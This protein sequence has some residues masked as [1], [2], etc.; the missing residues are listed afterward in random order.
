V[1]IPTAGGYDSAT[2]SNPS[3]ALTDFTLIIDLSRMSSSWW[4]DVNTSDGTRGRASKSDG[5]T[6]LACDWIDF[7]NSEET[8]LLRVKFSGSLA[9]SGTQTIRIYPP[10]TR[11]AAYS[12]SDTYGS[13]NAYDSNTWGYYPLHDGNDRTSNSRDLTAG[14]S[15][16]FGGGT[17]LIGSATDFDGSDDYAE[18]SADLDFASGYS[19]STLV[20]FDSS[21]GDQT[22]F[23]SADDSDVLFWRD[24][25]SSGDRLGIYYPGE[26][27]GYDTTTLSTA[28]WYHAGVAGGSTS[29]IYL[30]GSSAA[31]GGDSS[32]TTSQHPLLGAWQTSARHLDGRMQHA[33][34]SSTERAAAWFSHESDQLRD[35]ATFWGTW[36]W[37]ALSGGTT[38]NETIAETMSLSDSAAGA[39]TI[40]ATIAEAMSV[41]DA[42]GSVLSID[43]LISEALSFSDTIGTEITFNIQID[44]SFVM[45]D[46]AFADGQVI[47]VTINESFS[48]SDTANIS[49]LVEAVI[50]ESFNLSD[51]TDA[52]L[53]IDVTIDESLSL[54]DFL[55]TAAT[56]NIILSE[57]LVLS[58]TISG[59][60]LVDGRMSLTVTAKQGGITVTSKAGGITV[61]YKH[62][63]ITISEG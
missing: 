28:T 5:T 26:T 42:A 36:S 9:A 19:F 39:L 14:G 41:G 24:E 27:S 21:S 23:G 38:Y 31:S 62:G 18:P 20:N 17:G 63:N 33:Y 6:E 8:G 13:D 56:Y 29:P 3:S 37:T 45:T 2:I 46:A 30:N 57:Q 15:L 50:N 59:G 53:S 49:A 4:S 40:N 22:L 1:A 60:D 34:I 48:L 47:D 44:E 25:F 11:N 12:A 51:S 52:S 32:G 58:D 7:D 55:A 54:A 35:N 43:A 16:T 61:T 10:N